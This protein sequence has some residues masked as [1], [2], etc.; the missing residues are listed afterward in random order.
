MLRLVWIIAKAASALALLPTSASLA[1]IA[2]LLQLCEAVSTVRAR[3]SSCHLLSAV[4]SAVVLA[5]CLLLLCSLDAS[6]LLLC[7]RLCVPMMCCAALSVQLVLAVGPFGLI[8]ST[9]VHALSRLVP[10]TPWKIA[11]RTAAV[12]LQDSTVVV[13]H[14]DTLGEV[15]SSASS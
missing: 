7:G 1:S 5:S 2:G 15:S 4:C 9:E 11:D 14:Q 3:P 13:A 10:V 6:D 8:A 12:T